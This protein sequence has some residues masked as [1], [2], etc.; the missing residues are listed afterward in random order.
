MKYLVE[1]NSSDTPADFILRELENEF[2]HAPERDEDPDIRK[3]QVENGKI[4][5]MTDPDNNR[6]WITIESISGEKVHAVANRIEALLDR[7][8]ERGFIVWSQM[9]I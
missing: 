6:V 3:L 7:S 1:L 9:A 2:T 5:V 4:L 8:R